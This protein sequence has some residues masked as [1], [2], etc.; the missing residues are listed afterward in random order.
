MKH[1]SQVALDAQCVVPAQWP[2]AQAPPGQSVSAVQFVGHTVGTVIGSVRSDVAVPP[3]RFVVVSVTCSGRSPAA[4]TV[5]VLDVSEPALIVC[6]SPSSV[7]ANVSAIG[8]APSGYEVSSG[9]KGT[10][11]KCRDDIVPS[12]RIDVRCASP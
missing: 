3:A 7:H 1:G 8:I 9:G 6:A 4:V 5:T 10:S 2:L 11:A 12:I